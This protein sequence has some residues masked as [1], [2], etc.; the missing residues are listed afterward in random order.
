MSSSVSR[1]GYFPLVVTH[2]ESKCR[3]ARCEIW[4][5]TEMSEYDKLAALL[6]IPPQTARITLPLRPG[7]I[8][9][10][11]YVEDEQWYRGQILEEVASGKGVYRLQFVDYGNVEVVDMADMVIPSREH[12]AIPPLGEKF[13]LDGISPRNGCS[14]ADF[15]MDFLKQKLVNQEFTGEVVDKGTTGFPATI[16]LSVDLSSMFKPPHLQRP[17]YMNITREDNLP[18]D[19]CIEVELT[20][21]DSKL[22][23]WVQRVSMKCHVNKLNEE[24]CFSEWWSKFYFCF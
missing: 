2:V 21:A 23:F 4:V 7:D 13:I 6:E 18:I 17:V 1:G 16:R 11:R 24:V 19:L 5:Q 10:A 9:L 15:E 12:C 22:N 8:V 14:W 20:H 3:G